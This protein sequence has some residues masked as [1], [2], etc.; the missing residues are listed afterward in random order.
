MIRY[1]FNRPCVT[2]SIFKIG[3]MHQFTIECH[4]YNKRKTK[5]R[6]HHTAKPEGQ[7][8]SPISIDAFVERAD[9]AAETE[10]GEEEDEQ[11]HPAR[12]RRDHD[13]VVL[14]DAPPPVTQEVRIATAQI[15][16][17]I[18]IFILT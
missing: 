18:C 15:R 14:A 10:A 3:H 8:H 5:E 1:G 2:K 17:V 7:L 9:F 4:F 13:Q 12:H 11:G 6:V 16:A